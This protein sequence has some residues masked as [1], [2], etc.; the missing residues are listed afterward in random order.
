MLPGSCTLPLGLVK[1]ALRLCLRGWRSLCS[2]AGDAP[3]HVFRALRQGLDIAC[4]ELGLTAAAF[5]PA[6]SLAGSAGPTMQGVGSDQLH[7]GA[8]SGQAAAPGPATGQVQR[9]PSA[10]Q[11]GQAGGSRPSSGAVKVEMDLTED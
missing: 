7:T 8:G 5:M 3:V 1:L 9:G 2:M 10:K 6:V 11:Q 4:T